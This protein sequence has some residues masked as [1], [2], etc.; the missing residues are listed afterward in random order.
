MTILYEIIWLNLMKFQIK[1]TA[2][3][4]WRNFL[5]HYLIGVQVTD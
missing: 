4:I 5:F 3:T 1:L 2:D